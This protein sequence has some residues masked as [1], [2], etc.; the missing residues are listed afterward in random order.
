MV[1]VGGTPPEWDALD[2]DLRRRFIASTITRL[3]IA[4]SQRQTLVVV[5]EDLQ[6]TDSATT[7]MLGSLAAEVAGH[8]ILVLASFRPEFEPP[9]LGKVS[10]RQIRLEPLSQAEVEELVQRLIDAAAVP[11]LRRQLLRWSGGNPLFLRESIRALIDEQIIGEGAEAHVLLREPTHIT[12]PVSIAAIIAERVDRLPPQSKDIL[13]AASVLGEQFSLEVLAQIKGLPEALTMWHLQL[14]EEASFIRRVSIHLEIVFEF[15]HSLV[16]EVCYTTL[17]RRKRHELHAA[18][19]PVLA[20]PDPDGSAAPIELLAHHAFQGRLWK[21]AVPLCRTAG[22]RAMLR[23]SNREAARHF[24]N[25]L[26]ALDQVDPDGRRIEDAI[27]L[28]LELRAAQLPFLQLTKIGDLLQ[29]AYALSQQLG[30]K[31]QLARVTGFMAAQAYLTRGPE[32]CASLSRRSLHIARHTGDE[33]LQIA[34]NLYLAQAQYAFGRYR[35]AI[36]LLQRNLHLIRRCSS[37][38]SLGLPGRPLVMSLYWIAISKA[39]IGEFQE[40]EEVARR[41]L[42]DENGPQPFDSVYAQTALGFVQLVRGELEAALEFSAK[43]LEMA[44]ENDIKLLV[45]VLA[46]QVGWLL[47]Q[48]RQPDKGLTLARRAIQTAEAIGVQAGRSRWCARLAETCMLAGDMTEATRH[49]Q[50]AIALAERG[51]E[52]AYLCSALR[53]RGTIACRSGHLESGRSDLERATAIAERLAIGPMVAKCLLDMG[54]LESSAL[55]PAKAQF[56]IRDAVAGFRRYRM[57]TWEYR[58]EQELARLGGLP[59][60][61]ENLPRSGSR[62]KLPRSTGKAWRCATLS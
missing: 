28:R 23:S 38:V 57:T 54:Y 51:A 8:R 62:A 58:A 49:V 6:R 41:M 39:E 21:E 14:I 22:R 26:T 13:L 18:A 32:A 20:N 43:A 27:E 24:E 4:E 7:E 25:A 29:E 2:S 40:A 60:A 46:S 10:H 42:A 1:E 45:P 33:S 17:L 35:Q 50:T 61:A 36:A 3:L 53:L 55:N 12:P 5:I 15:C 52:F 19:F 11:R 37:T 9:W 44:D 34:P 56:L 30:D 31:E 16:Q 59:Q 48:L 47:A